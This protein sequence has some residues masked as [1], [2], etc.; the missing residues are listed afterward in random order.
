[1][2][3]DETTRARNQND[4][5]NDFP[6]DDAAADWRA[7]GQRRFEAAYAPEDSIYESLIDRAPT[8]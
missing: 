1:M 6:E 7:A 2:N 3:A 4:S 8:E 5:V